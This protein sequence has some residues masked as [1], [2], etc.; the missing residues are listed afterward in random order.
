MGDVV[1]FPEGA[2]TNVQHLATDVLVRLFHEWDGMECDSKG[3]D[4]VKGY[5]VRA[6]QEEVNR[7]GEGW[8]V[9]V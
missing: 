3:V 2:R 7:R 1:R 8:K 9:A 6:I 5:S 4:S